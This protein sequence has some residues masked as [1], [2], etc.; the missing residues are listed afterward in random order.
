MNLVKGRDESELVFDVYLPVLLK[1]EQGERGFTPEVGENSNW[2]IG[3]EDTGKPSRGVSPTVGANGNWWIG[4][5]DTGVVAC[6]VNG[7]DGKDGRDI[8]YIFQRT[9]NGVRPSTPASEQSDDFVP[10][11]WTDDP[12]GVDG[13]FPYEWVCKRVCAGGVW[14]GFSVPAL[15]ANFSLNGKN[16]RDGADGADGA[17]GETPVIGENGNWFIG[18]E[19]TKKPSRGLPGVNGSDIVEVQQITLNAPTS[20]ETKFYLNPDKLIHYIYVY[21]QRGF[22]HSLSLDSFNPIV[23]GVGHFVVIVNMEDDLGDIY[24]KNFIY[25]KDGAKEYKIEGGEV[26]CFVSYPTSGIIMKASFLCAGYYNNNY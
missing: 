8:E 19:D 25:S 26:A 12:V 11:G 14:S 9:A 16:G 3:G 24:I 17:G 6:A 5:E 7:I 20:G 21:K 13:V 1:G 18:G 10:S 22:S 23:I 15:W 4:D 2:W